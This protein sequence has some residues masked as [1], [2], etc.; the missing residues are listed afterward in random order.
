MTKANADVYKLREQNGG[1]GGW[2]QTFTGIQFFPFDPKPEEISELDIAHS[3]ACMPRFGGHTKRFYTVGDHSIIMSHLF[4]IKGEIELARKALFHDAA[5]AYVLDMPRP[6]KYMPEMAKYKKLEK[7][8]QRVIFEKFGLGEESP[9]IKAMDTQLVHNEARDLMS[10][11]H[12]E[13]TNKGNEIPG[14]Y[15]TPFENP[16]ITEREFLKLYDILFNDAKDVKYY[17]PAILVQ[18]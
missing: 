11:L 1:R 14:L 2:L 15:I 7:D 3:L 17:V 16:H 5:E 12:E 9:E 18:I 8:I 10:P 6:I 13:W 4:F